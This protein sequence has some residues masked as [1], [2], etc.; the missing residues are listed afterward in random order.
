MQK[1]SFLK[2]LLGALGQA[3][4]ANVMSLIV[5]FSLITFG[6]NTVTKSIAAFCSVSLY[7]MLLFN[8]GHKDGEID[9]K[10]LQ[11][12]TIEKQDGDKWYIIGAIVALLFCVACVFLFFFT[13]SGG[14]DGTGISADGGY[15]SIFRVVFASVMA[16]SLLFGDSVIP[17]WSPFV[18]MAIF[19]LA[20]FA[21][22]LGYWVG[23]HEKWRLENIMYEKKK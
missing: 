13:G 4:G 23:F 19:S 11:R 9:R 20:P 12:K 21:G 6:M 5:T 10:L 22:R 1:K 14:E 7:L 15:L 2:L 16:V 3:L 18:F 8:A 17:I